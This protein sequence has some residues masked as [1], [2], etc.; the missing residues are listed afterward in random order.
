MDA[1]I[2]EISEYVI[3]NNTDRYDTA[4]DLRYQQMTAEYSA[5]KESYDRI[6]YSIVKLDKNNKAITEQ[7][8]DEYVSMVELPPSSRISKVNDR[9]DFPG[10]TNYFIDEAKA[11][12]VL[13]PFKQG[14]WEQLTIQEQKQAVEKLADYNA[15]ILGVEDKPR[16]IYYNADD[17]CE[18]QNAIYVNENNMHDAAETADTISHEYRHKY[19]DE[20]LKNSKP[21]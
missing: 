8:G 3:S 9:S 12:E 20:R 7:L 4:H 21:N 17:P 16:I 5:M 13:S 18:K 15:E 2:D 1:N 11:F 19:Q 6:G 14:N 10:E